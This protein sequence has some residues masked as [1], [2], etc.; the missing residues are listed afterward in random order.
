M[1]VRF[2]NGPDIKCRTPGKMDH[3]NTELVQYSDVDCSWSRRL[4]TEPYLTTFVGP[5]QVSNG[6]DQAV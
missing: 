2:S 6:R 5:V 3:L 4:K 1:N